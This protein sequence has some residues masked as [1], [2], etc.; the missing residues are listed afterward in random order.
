[1]STKN[2]LS[3]PRVLGPQ[4][5]ERSGHSDYCVDRYILDGA[6]TQGRLSIVEHI[7]AP[8]A[9]AGPMHIHT[10]ED[11]YSFVIEGTVA[12]VFGGEEVVAGAGDFV[13]KPRGEWHTFWNPTDSVTR[14]LEIITPP[15]LED[16]FRKLGDDQIDPETL[17][18]LA[19]EWGCE[20][21]FEATQAI[22]Q[23]HG[24]NF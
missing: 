18:A 5:G 20:V 4:E 12:A 1:M 6:E 23:K 21:D 8:H 16:L 17:P 14:I 7:L 22:I 15:G 2:V 9:L 19:A 3:R 24:L 11:E 13:F 10:R